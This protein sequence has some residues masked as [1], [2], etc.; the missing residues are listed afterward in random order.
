MPSW[1]GLWEVLFFIPKALT[2]L[3]MTVRCLRELSVMGLWPP[4]LFLFY[5]HLK[6]WR[7]WCNSG[8]LLLDMLRWYMMQYFVC[9][10]NIFSCSFLAKIL[11]NFLNNSRAQITNHSWYI[12]FLLTR[13]VWGK[14]E[15]NKSRAG[16][17]S[18][19]Y[20]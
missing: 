20:R 6:L 5:S 13:H 16:A 8:I 7:V 15:L 3:W 10:Q 4:N 19:L 12:S 14:M 2:R 9:T 18:R 17:S 1:K 11:C